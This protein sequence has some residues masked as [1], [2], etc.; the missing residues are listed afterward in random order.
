MVPDFSQNLK[1]LFTY[2]GVRRREEERKVLVITCKRGQKTVPSIGAWGEGG[3]R[4]EGG[5]WGEGGAGDE[6]PSPTF[7]L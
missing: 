4:G 1:A 2:T 5:T 7:D 6:G 3:T